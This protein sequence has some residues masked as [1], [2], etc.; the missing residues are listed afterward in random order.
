MPANL[1][2]FVSTGSLHFRENGEEVLTGL[3]P[4]CIVTSGIALAA[5]PLGTEVTA[6]QLELFGATSLLHIS[7]TVTRSLPRKQTWPL[8]FSL[9]RCRSCAPQSAP[10]PFTPFPGRRVL[11]ALLV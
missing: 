4:S 6:L 2:D 1:H 11:G 8:S 9:R 5:P 7:E 3:Y 10:A